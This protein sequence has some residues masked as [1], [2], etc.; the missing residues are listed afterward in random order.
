MIKGN[1]HYVYNNT[2]FDSVVKNDIMVL[3]TQSGNR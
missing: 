3:N 2:G 1:H